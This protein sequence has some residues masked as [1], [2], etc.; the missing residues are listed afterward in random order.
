MAS[1]S[2]RPRVEE[3]DSNDS[4]SGFDFIENSTE[5]MDIAGVSELDRL[6]A[7]ESEISR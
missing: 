2:Y 7:D 3:N 6:L 4:E 5:G 1:S